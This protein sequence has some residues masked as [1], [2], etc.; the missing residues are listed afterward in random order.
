[1]TF[2]IFCGK[3][4]RF[5]IFC[6]KKNLATLICIHSAGQV[7]LAVRNFVFNWTARKKM[8]RIELPRKNL[9]FLSKYPDTLRD[10]QEQ[11]SGVRQ[12][13]FFVV[14]VFDFWVG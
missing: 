12:L 6:T 13:F 1:M 2:V 7:L 5:G 9:A 14:V 11:R 4:Y 10:K 8:K 3:F